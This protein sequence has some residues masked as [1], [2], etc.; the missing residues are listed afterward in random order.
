MEQMEL[1]NNLCFYFLCP[2]KLNIKASN[3]IV[4]HHLIHGR[5]MRKV[6]Y[7]NGVELL[8]FQKLIMKYYSENNCNPLKI[9]L[10]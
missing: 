6:I 7:D 4:K 8:K 3:L 9:K 10:I 1:V 2:Q 5:R